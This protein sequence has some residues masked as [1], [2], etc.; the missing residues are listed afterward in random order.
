MLTQKRRFSFPG[1]RSQGWGESGEGERDEQVGVPGGCPEAWGL[2]E[3]LLCADAQG[4]AKAEWPGEG[5]KLQ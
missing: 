3:R 5:E 1:R 4:W 2:Q